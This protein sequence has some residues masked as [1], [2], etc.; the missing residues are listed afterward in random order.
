MRRPDILDRLKGETPKAFAAFQEWCSN[1]H[2]VSA[3][4]RKLRGNRND[5]QRWKKE[6][7][8][9]ERA[10]A[11]E[12]WEAIVHDERVHR[13]ADR[14]AA[15]LIERAL[16]FVKKAK[17]PA[18]LRA[19]ALT[20]KGTAS[21]KRSMLGLIEEAEEEHEAAS[22][23]KDLSIAKQPEKGVAEIIE[24]VEAEEAE[25]REATLRAV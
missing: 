14:L 6:H 7:A 9:E 4:V 2:N 13:Q 24:E 8:W 19:I 17:T 25:E 21:A 18:E 11:E 15:A 10:R 20:F 16:G 1:G 5:Y 12:R 3:A 23:F 22:I